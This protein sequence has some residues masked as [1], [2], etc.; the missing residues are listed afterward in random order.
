M[1]PAA[2]E[3][4]AWLLCD[5]TGKQITTLIEGFNA[6]LLH[7]GITRNSCRD[8]FKLY[9]LRHFYAVMGIRSVLDVYA[10]ARNMGTSVAMIEVYYGRAATPQSQAAALGGRG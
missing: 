1:G 8:K 7:A 9:S 10:I 3:P 5:H 6:L 4:N 2:F